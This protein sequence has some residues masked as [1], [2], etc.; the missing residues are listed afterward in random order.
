ML[1]VTG[2]KEINLKVLQF[3]FDDEQLK[4]RFLTDLQAVHYPDNKGAELAVVY[5]LH[6]LTDNIR[7]RFDEWSGKRRAGRSGEISAAK[8]RADKRREKREIAETIPPTI[9]VGEIERM[10]AAAAAGRSMPLFDDEPSIPTI[11]NVAE[12]NPFETVKVVEPPEFEEVFARKRE[13]KP[14]I[15]AEQTFDEDDELPA[16]TSTVSGQNFDK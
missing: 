2:Q 5:H 1:T 8:M 7:I 11:D 9:S 14:V 16:A 3:L 4:F 13:P 15:V 6:N 10:A 12:G